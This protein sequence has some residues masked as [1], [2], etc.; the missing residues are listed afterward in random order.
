MAAVRVRCASGDRWGPA[1][2]ICINLTQCPVS[3]HR[4][5]QKFARPMDAAHFDARRR[6]DGSSATAAA[7]ASAPPPPAPKVV[8]RWLAFESKHCGVFVCLTSCAACALQLSERERMAAELGID[9]AD[10]SDDGAAS[11]GSG[12]HGGTPGSSGGGGPTPEERKQLER[13]PV[14]ESQLSMLRGRIESLESDVKAAEAARKRAEDSAAQV[15]QMSKYSTVVMKKTY[16]GKLRKQQEL[17]AKMVATV[18]EREES[19]AGAGLEVADPKAEEYA[20]ESETASS[21][22]VSAAA[23][24]FGMAGAAAKAREAS[25]SDADTSGP[26]S[27]TALTAAANGGAGSIGGASSEEV[28]AMEKELEKA[29]L[30]NRKLAADMQEARDQLAALTG[31]DKE[32]AEQARNSEVDTLRASLKELEAKYSKAKTMGRH[33]K[34]RLD[35]AKPALEAAQSKIAELEAAQG[36][37]IAELQSKLAQA[38]DGAKAATSASEEVASLKSRV[39]ELEEAVEALEGERDEAIEECRTAQT[40]TEEESNKVANLALRVMNLE[41]ELEKHSKDGASAGAQLDELRGKLEQ[42]SA[43]LKEATDELETTRT[44]LSTASAQLDKAT[45]DKTSAT[46]KLQEALANAEAATKAQSDAE[47]RAAKAEASATSQVKATKEKYKKRE[48]KLRAAAEGQ[49]KK[50][51]EAL[52]QELAQVEAAERSAKQQLQSRLDDA[53]SQLRALMESMRHS[54]QKVGASAHETRQ[55]WLDLRETTRSEF[56]SFVPVVSDTLSRIVAKVKSSA[57]TS[58]TVIA[59][60]RKEMAERRRLFNLVQELRGNIRVYCRVRPMMEGEQKAGDEMAMEFPEAGEVRVRNL[61]KQVKK[62]EFEQV[63]HPDSTNAE[64]YKEVEGLITSVMDGYNVCIFAYGQTG[65]GKTHTMEGTADNRGINYRALASLFELYE[66]RSADH[67][68]VIR[69]SLLEIYNEAIRDMLVREQPSKLK[70][71]AGAHGMVVPGLTISEVHSLDE[72]RALMHTGY[73]NRTTFA[74][75]MNEHSSRSHCMLSVYVELTNKISGAVSRG[76]LHLVDLAGSERL[77]KTGATGDRLKEAQNINKSLSALG[78]VIAARAQKS[79]HIPFRNST[80]TFLLS[81]SLS[82][83]SK[84]LMFVNLSPILASADESFCSLNFASRV[85]TVEL[86]RASK[87]VDRMSGGAGGRSRS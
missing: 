74:T 82:E 18:R 69:C 77:S 10:F 56:D 80:L 21:A 24:A 23:S 5:P 85:R 3:G 30:A 67:D 27:P 86:G 32:A 38:E 40:E 83:N 9:E 55:S 34:N 72:V 12:G 36:A 49:L 66:D 11:D 22:A 87:N 70:V 68:I 59:R 25:G 73:S 15:K 17:I 7:P 81:D 43:E 58:E 41:E 1:P 28:K 35:Q 47:D 63:F 64:V 51:K 65:S 19:L 79:G 53:R 2:Q 46:E 60:Y 13:V 48:E 57:A 54:V 31:P 42:T 61:K 45:G 50:M 16:E 4:T 44:R 78:D 8:R 39:T 6:R 84:T 62:W 37:Q 14:L 20:K 29:R 26:P 71:T 76:K 75:N 33:L 52:T